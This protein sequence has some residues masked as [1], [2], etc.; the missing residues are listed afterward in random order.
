[1]SQQPQIHW[2]GSLHDCGQACGIGGSID[3][4]VYI[5]TPVCRITDLTPELV[6]AAAQKIEFAIRLQLQA[7]GKRAAVSDLPGLHYAE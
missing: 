2:R 5:A 7:A 3:G 1:M 6:I 4:A